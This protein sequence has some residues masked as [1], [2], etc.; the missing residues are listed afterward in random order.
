MIVDR[1]KTEFF[2][3]KV[4][5]FY[6]GKINIFNNPARLIIN[7]AEQRDSANGGFTINP[8]VVTINPNVVA[9]YSENEYVLYRYLL[10]V[11]IHELYHVDQIIDYT[12][13][14]GVDANYTDQIE[15]A[16]E[17][18]TNIYIA[19]HKLEILYNFGLDIE[20]NNDKFREVIYDYDTSAPAIYQRRNFITH[21]MCVVRE[22][23]ESDNN[24][25]NLFR[26][27]MDNYS[28]T[29]K[30]ELM[31]VVN[32]QSLLVLKNGY[33]CTTYQFNEF[34][35]NNFLRYTWRD[36]YRTVFDK[37]DKF[38]INLDITGQYIMCKEKQNYEK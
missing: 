7:W 11:I 20:V 15:S 33:T 23:I 18:Q 25:Y 9:R 6:N 4:F 12:R 36:G 5:N 31:I 32:D 24:G 29:S 19:N 13:M 10:E 26:N 14:G 34:I 16:V 8:N 2:I 1:G 38:I 27:F 28:R 3:E 21:I 30:G 35:Y 17:V 22:L 37:G